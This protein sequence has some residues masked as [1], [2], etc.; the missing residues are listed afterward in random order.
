MTIYL[1][2]AFT[3]GLTT[4]A[5]GTVQSLSAAIESTAV[6]QGKA[7]YID[8]QSRAPSVL[9]DSAGRIAGLL[10][11]DGS[12]AMFP[13]WSLD[14]SGNVAGLVGSGGGL[15]LSVIF[16]PPSGDTTGATDTARIQAKINALALGTL[17]TSIAGDARAVNGGGTVALAPG[18]IYDIT[19]ISLPPNVTLAGAGMASTTLRVRGTGPGIVKGSRGSV[20][21]ENNAGLSDLR[22][23]SDGTG[24]QN[25]VLFDT[26]DDIVIRNVEIQGFA[27]YGLQLM[28]SQYLN[29]F[30]L[31]I[32]QCGTG[33]ELADNAEGGT[34]PCNNNHF[35][36]LHVFNC[37]TGV[38]LSGHANGIHGGTIQ[39]N[40]TLGLWIRGFAVFGC[41]FP[42]V[43]NVH[44]EYHNTQWDI[45]IDPGVLCASIR[46]CYFVPPVG[47]KTGVRY[48]RNRGDR[49]IIDNCGTTKTDISV[50]GSPAV[51]QQPSSGGDVL[52]IGGNWGNNLSETVWVA[53]EVHSVSAGALRTQ[54][55]CINNSSGVPTL[56]F[57]AGGRFFSHTVS[58]AV[59]MFYGANANPAWRISSW[60]GANARAGIEL[61]DGSAAPD[62]IIQRVAANVAQMAAGDSFGVSGA[63][64]A[65]AAAPTA[66]LRLGSYFLWVDNTNRLRI[67]TAAPATSTDGTVVGTQT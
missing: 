15:A 33:L 50:G 4:L 64:T 45:D 34:F 2:S 63:S 32:L 3:T 58:D 18:S 14:A 27:G 44:F 53:D 42:L 7:L 30:K 55:K 24:G 26:V 48:I 60:D 38:I 10:D 59:E 19:Q 36:G 54:R 9:Q 21:G 22:I 57:A 12:V 11:A 40:T 37:G 43:E 13:N 8:S 6:A 49:T 47:G 46:S 1:H 61:G 31:H 25:G 17:D 56:N 62:T 51:I 66:T 29:A 41:A 16:V 39:G 65:T 35:Y 67:H 23:I 52:V 5:A 20:Y 28:K